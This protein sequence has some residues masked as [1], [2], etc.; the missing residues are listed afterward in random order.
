MSLKDLFNEEKYQYLAATSLNDLTGTIESPEYITAYIEKKRRVVPRVDY[1]KPENFARFGSAEKYLYDSITRVYKTYPYDGSKKEKIIWELSS[2]LLDLYLFENEYPRTTGYAIFTTASL[3]ATDTSVN[4]GAAGTS[5]YEYIFV[6]GGPHSGSG[7]TTYLDPDSGEAKYRKNANIWD[8]AKSR[9]CNLKIGGTDG[10]TIEFWLKKADFEPAATEKE[11]IFDIHTI[12]S[13][14]SSADYGRLRIEMSGHGAG[15]SFNTLSPFYVTYMSGTT[16]FAN[17][18]IGSSITT[19]SIADNNWHHYAF[20][21]KN[22]GSNVVTDLFVDG[23]HNHRVTTGTAVNYVSG[24]IAGTIGALATQPSGTHAGPP[25]AT[26]GWGKLSG[27]IDELRY[28]K[29]WKNS[30]HIQLRWFDQIGGGTNTDDSNTDLGVYYKFN[31]GIIGASSIDATVLDY[32]GRV[33]NGS[34]TGYNS[35]YSRN[36]GS[37]INEAITTRF[38]GSEYRDPIMYPNHP[39]TLSFLATKRTEGKLYD[40]TNQSNLYYSLPTWLIEEHEVTTTEGEGISHNHL[41]NLIQIMSSYFDDLATKI[42]TLPNI[43]QPDY[44]TGSLKPLPFMDRLLEGKDFVNPEIFTALNAL[45]VFEGREDDRIYTE[46]IHDLKNII[47]R[48]I[49][50]NLLYINKSKGTEKSFRNLIRCFGVDDKIYHLNTYSN[51]ADFTLNKNYRTVSE[52]Y[53]LINFNIKENSDASIYQFSSSLNANSTTFIS[54][55]E[56]YSSPLADAQENGLSFSI[57]TNITFPNRASSY[58]DVRNLWDGEEKYSNNYP[59]MQTASLFG[60]H[61]AISDEPEETTWSSSDYANFIVKAIKPSLYS[62]KAY[63]VLTGTL[64]TVLPEL[65]SSEFNDVYKDKNWNFMVSLYPE[66][67][68]NIDQIPGTSGSLQNTYIIEFAGIYNVLDFSVNE[69]RVTGSITGEQARNFLVSPK[70]I[71]AGAH[72]TNFTGSLLDTTDVKFNNLRA[73]QNRL[74]MADLRRH[75]A[76]PN[77]YGISS[78][79]QNAYLFNTSINNVYVPKEE[80]LLLHWNFSN[81]TASDSNGT[82]LVDDLTSG[83]V[84]QIDRYGWLSKIKKQQ[85]L[86]KAYEFISSSTKVC[87]TDEIIS[88]K[89]NLPEV[90]GSDDTITVMQNDDIYFTRD[91]RP[92]FFDL[93]VEKSPYQNISAEMMNFISTAADFNDI[94]GQPVDKYR[95][96]YKALNMLRQL[97]FERIKDTPNI[98]KYVEYFKW[99]DLAVSAM[100]QKI[101]PMSSGLDE[102]PLRNIIE[103]HILERNKYQNKFP[104]YEFKQSDPVASMLGVHG[105][106]Y[107]WKYGHP[108][109]EPFNEKSLAI[110]AA[111]DSESIITVSDADSLSFGADGTAGNE[112]AFSISAWIKPTDRDNFRIVYKGEDVL[113][114]N[115]EYSFNLGTNGWLSFVIYD[116]NTGGSLTLLD[117]T[118]YAYEGEWAHICATY[119]GSQLH[120]GLKIYLNGVDQSSWTGTGGGYIAMDN[121]GEDLTIGRKWQ[122]T[123]AADIADGFI[124]ELAI[125][126]KNLS[127]SEVLS[128]Y[129]RGFITDLATHTAF[130]DIVSWW[131][132]GDKATGTSPNYTIPDQ[133]GSNN[134]TLTGFRGDTTSGVVPFTAP[135]I[136]MADAAASENKNCLWWKDRAPRN[137]VVIT[138]GDANVDSNRNTIL[139]IVNNENNASAPNLSGSSG[140]YEGSTYAIRKFARPYKLNVDAQKQIH[141]GT[142]FNENRDIDLWRQGV[143]KKGFWGS[144]SLSLADV[145][146]VRYMNISAS[147]GWNACDNADVIDPNKKKYAKTKVKIYNDLEYADGFNNA[148]E[149]FLNAGKN[150]LPFNIISSS[151]PTTAAGYLDG[152]T[153]ESTGLVIVNL[154]ND[155]YGPAMEKPMQ[156]PFTNT[157]VGGPQHRHIDYAT[158]SQDRNDRPENFGIQ[159]KSLS[160]VQPRVP[161]LLN[162]HTHQVYT[163]GTDGGNNFYQDFNK[164]VAL[165]YRDGTAKRPVNIA[166]INYNTG[167]RTLGNYSQPYELV[168]T[169]DRTVNNKFLMEAEGNILTASADNYYVSGAVDFAL[170][171]RDLTGSNKYIIANRFSAPGDPATMAEGMLDVEAGEYSVYNALP[172]R[173]L[174]VRQP[175]NE[176]HADHCKQFG[177]FSD[178]FNSASYVLAGETYPGTSGSVREANYNGSAS[179]HKIN[180]NTRK[181]PQYSNAY[182]GLDG[183]VT[184]ASIHDNWFVQHQIPQSDMQYAWIT[185]SVINDYNGAAKFG[186]EQPDF[187]N[188]SLASTDL[189]FCSASNYGSFTLGGA[190]AIRYWGETYEESLG[191]GATVWGWVPVDFAGMNTN[192]YEPITSSEN[193]MGYPNKIKWHG[194]KTFTYMG[195]MVDKTYNA[196]TADANVP[197]V[198]N[199]ILLNRNGPYQ[200]PSWKQLRGEQHPIIRMHRQENRISYLDR[201]HV[202]T[203]DGVSTTWRDRIT[204]SIEPMITSKYKPMLHTLVVKQA[205]GPDYGTTKPGTAS[206]GHTYMNNKVFF[207]DHF[208]DGVNLDNKILDPRKNSKTE[209]Q[210]LD[211]INYY[212]H[213]NDFVKVPQL[214]PITELVSY[215]VKETIFPKE[216]FTYLSKIRGRDDYSC[217]FWRETHAERL[218]S[219]IVNSMDTSIP[220]QSIWALDGRQNIITASP[221]SGGFDGAGELLSNGAVYWDTAVYAPG[222][223]YANPRRGKFN[224]SPLYT[225]PT[226]S[227]GTGPLNDVSWDAGVQSGLDPFAS[228]YAA[229]ALE[230][231]KLGKDFG[232]IPEFRISEYIGDYLDKGLS[233]NA[234]NPNQAGQSDKVFLTLTG[235]VLDNTDPTFYKTYSNT[236]FLKYFAT[237]N[238]E[239]DGTVISDVK[240]KCKAMM[241]FLPYD[242]F[243]PVQRTIQLAELF[244]ASYLMGIDSGSARAGLTPFFA[245]GIMY[246][247][248]KAG[249]AVDFPVPTGSYVT[250]AWGSTS[251]GARKSFYEDANQTFNRIPFESIISPSAVLK[252]DELLW[253]DIHIDPGSHTGDTYELIPSSGNEVSKYELATNNFFAETIN[254]F[255]PEGRMSRIVSLPGGHSDFGF[256]QEKLLSGAE[257]IPTYKMRVVLTNDKNPKLTYDLSAQNDTKFYNYKDIS[258]F[259]PPITI[260]TATNIGGGYGAYAPPYFMGFGANS[261]YGD[262]NSWGYLEFEWSPEEQISDSYTFAT[263]TDQLTSSFVGLNSLSSFSQAMSITASINI[264]VGNILNTEYSAITGQPLTVSDSG[265]DEL[266]VLIIEPKWEC[267]MLNFS[268]SS[269]TNIA[270]IGDTGRIGMWHQTGSIDESVGVYL[271]IM[272]H[273]DQDNKTIGSLADLMG[274]NKTK[275]KIPR[276]LGKVAASKEISE[277][278]VAIPFRVIDNKKVTYKITRDAI[279]QAELMIK[280]HVAGDG[281]LPEN[282]LPDHSIVDMVRKMQRYVIPP[283]MDF[284]SYSNNI[285]GPGGGIEQVLGGPFAMYIFE[286]K[287]QLTQQDLANIWQNLP[288]TSMGAA[289]YYHESD[290]V[291]ISHKVFNTP[292]L[293][294]LNGQNFISESEE[295]IKSQQIVEEIRWMVFKV[296][297]RAATNYTDKTT[298]RDDGGEYKSQFPGVTGTEIPNITYNWPYDYFSMVELIK[299]DAEITMKPLDGIVNQNPLTGDKEEHFAADFFGDIGEFMNGEN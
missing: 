153:D 31:E 188:A 233:I 102:R 147:D 221:I 259:G 184:T 113:F 86:G 139:E 18:N 298:D 290:E 257:P 165:Y 241:K 285:L 145:F 270:G 227:S 81:V 51:N 82:F 262:N 176:L 21:F 141:G 73:W 255:L 154:H 84:K 245:P 134:A 282:P 37:A 27:S 71:F 65:T 224:L 204:S 292:T 107:N 157:F 278:V 234:R 263:I 53:K 164:P 266:K 56:D 160:G 12:S 172:W 175:L 32:S 24:T 161:Y 96:E 155:V 60:M 168:L 67:H 136:T 299:L 173:N 280:G 297:K 123:T 8:S 5:S 217:P 295:N 294:L 17:Q 1:S 121:T 115:K 124:D 144:K 131:R 127:A 247:S 276:R 97:F 104:S 288:P 13:I 89:P 2:S 61:T 39:D 135:S 79:A 174:S 200:H 296:K 248:I 213:T 20:R 291:T 281:T 170:P 101:A 286:F 253:S 159:I 251:P 198:L 258:T 54:A 43:S 218:E 110:N 68:Q 88:A 78:P 100:I 183:T 208:S 232:I 93:Y 177:Y 59:L 46:K 237:R 98:D 231:Q 261:E 112:P 109:V 70:R 11:V 293:N 38:S 119:D 57:E 116:A 178:A 277:A 77:N 235:T 249:I 236:E 126:G 189:T 187:S 128:I 219:N 287:H 6:N 196:S 16:G 117:T 92:V 216:Q 197:K 271:K 268:S 242:G 76:D 28:W 62:N 45:E 239:N 151:L 272:D 49:Y 190:F 114:G 238:E 195:G 138:S 274:F 180:R 275:G 33:S 162:P 223:D 243:Y 40:Y 192:I 35:S 229:Y 205:V 199:A 36:T 14:S 256:T 23:R 146:K 85:Y 289:P 120:T 52:K 179:F 133:V 130:G 41:W 118:S 212:L 182:T 186:F 156:G 47:Y 50:N 220:S 26:K 169:N 158:S 267:P 171:R 64:G 246:N 191:G 185:A 15:P 29:S 106:R 225:M 209:Q 279:S 80:T 254:F 90:I 206:I 163:A 111:A 148:E 4:Y 105:M 132:M 265:A 149:T 9:E 230:M 260:N 252:G 215:T 193:M 226:S 30:E 99:F 58:A 228:S 48:N 83:S 66:K 129:N 211:V 63:F 42:K 250:G 69:F 269:Q 72:R 207:T 143:A 25:Q 167:S 3:T 87:V 181:Q 10:N 91:K 108:S 74:T 222:P 194:D 125:F 75:A 284:V 7:E 264:A 201:F 44:I 94:I 19:A 95:S 150:I 166:N 142:N 22:T 283:H 103:S 137:S 202:L 55:S 210:T 34:W 152:G 273:P 203:S 214:N 140:T 240:L 122:S 244:S